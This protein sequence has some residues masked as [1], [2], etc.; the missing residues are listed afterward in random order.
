[1]NVSIKKTVITGILISLSFSCNQRDAYYYYSQGY[2]YY[3][4][5]NYKL[6]IECYTKSVDI[7]DKNA[8]VYFARALAYDWFGE[9]ELA[10]AD[11]TSAIEYDYKWASAYYNRGMIYLIIFKMYDKAISDFEMA[12]VIDSLFLKPY[13]KLAEIYKRQ[14]KDLSTTYLSKIISIDSLNVEAYSLRGGNF[15]NQGRYEESIAD[16]DIAIKLEPDNYYFYS[17]RGGSYAFLGNVELAFRDIDKGIE[18]N[19]KNSKL[20]FFRARL[21]QN[22]LNDDEKA[23]EDYK[24]SADLGFEQAK[25]V[26]K[27]YYKIDY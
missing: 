4:E 24:K 8:D 3:Q 14:N 7:D 1:M 26:L 21:Y 10:I 15:F 12:I 13:F 27:D 22:F 9:K 17:V 2:K 11:Y 25:S 23:I 6:A 18:I 19:P 5:K 16:F 20:Y